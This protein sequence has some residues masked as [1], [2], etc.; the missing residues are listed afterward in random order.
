MFMHEEPSADQLAFQSLAPVTRADLLMK[1]QHARGTVN[2]HPSNNKHYDAPVAAITWLVEDLKTHGVHA[3]AAELEPRNDRLRTI[4]E[5]PKNGGRP[6]VQ[7]RV[8]GLLDRGF[9]DALKWHE[10][11]L[12]A[13]LKGITDTHERYMEKQ[14]LFYNTDRELPQG[15]RKFMYVTSQKGT[16]LKNFTDRDLYSLIERTQNLLAD[17][18]QRNPHE[19]ASWYLAANNHAR[20]PESWREVYASLQ[21]SSLP[22]QLVQASLGHHP[23]A[24]LY[25]E[26]DRHAVAEKIR[27]LVQPERG[28]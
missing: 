3:L 2:A 16:R 6:P 21:F 14:K 12:N 18:A 23:E 17:I 27:H 9:R 1:L 8:R 4:A 7:M 11:A 25:I 13:P 15:Y 24:G 20:E 26:Q 19:L 22:R 10:S 28:R 5:T